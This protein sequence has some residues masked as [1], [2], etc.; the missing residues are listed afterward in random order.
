MMCSIVFFLVEELHVVYHYYVSECEK[1]R[2][3]D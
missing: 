3:E 1:E 2:G